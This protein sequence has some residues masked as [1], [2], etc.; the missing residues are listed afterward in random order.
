[1]F[2]FSIKN[3]LLLGLAL[4]LIVGGLLL[5]RGVHSQL[6]ILE[7]NIDPQLTEVKE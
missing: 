5:G 6:E 3:I 1:M 7:K 4:L 2:N